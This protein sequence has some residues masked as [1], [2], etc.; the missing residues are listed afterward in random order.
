MSEPACLYSL[1]QANYFLH[2]LL[3]EYLPY[4]PVNDGTVSS[5]TVTYNIMNNE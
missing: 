1:P 3:I 4:S 2:F 5:E